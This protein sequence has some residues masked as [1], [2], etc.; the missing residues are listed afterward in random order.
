MTELE[1]TQLRHIVATASQL[2]T[3]LEHLAEC[4]EEHTEIGDDLRT[5]VANTGTWLL[6]LSMI[7]TNR[8]QTELNRKTIDEL[9]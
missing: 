2:V 6:P 7:A 1:E 3:S 8:L 9:D 4:V 5:Y